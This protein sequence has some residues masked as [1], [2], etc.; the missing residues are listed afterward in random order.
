[1]CRAISSWESTRAGF[2]TSSANSRNSVSVRSIKSP[3]LGPHFA[4]DEVENA[5]I[6]GMEARPR[7]RDVVLLDG[8][9]HAGRTPAHW[10][11]VAYRCA[12]GRQA[13]R[14]RHGDADARNGAIR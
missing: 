4:F 2:S 6:K 5:M 14:P 3:S 1:M 9:T 12:Y 13:R 10:Q 7:E 8:S 11:R